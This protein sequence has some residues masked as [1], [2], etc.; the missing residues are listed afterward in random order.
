M[1]IWQKLHEHGGFL[2]RTLVHGRNKGV[3]LCYHR[4]LP[5]ALITEYGPNTGLIMPEAQFEQQMRHLASCCTPMPLDQLLDTPAHTGKRP[6]VVTFDDGTAD[7]LTY[8]LP[9]LE[10]YQIPATVY[11]TTGFVLQELR[12]WWQLLW[13]ALASTDRYTLACEQLHWATA[14]HASKIEC[15]KHIHTL[16]L[17][18]TGERYQR[19]NAELHRT[20]HPLAPQD[21]YLTPSEVGQLAQHPLITIGLH[22]HTHTPTRVLSGLEFEHEMTTSAAYLHAWTARPSHHFAYPY[23]TQAVICNRAGYQTST[24]T[25]RSACTTVLGFAK[26][27][28]RYALSRVSIPASMRMPHFKAVVG[29][30]L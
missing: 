6:V 25:L 9:I 13:A 14:S 28:D 4:V 29:C 24:H 7:N 5:Q 16:M 22:T 2:V 11:V 15:F 20:V 8:A 1:G 19:I 12:P 21:R 26:P 18:G 27:D 30:Y 10:K 17:S 23:G 3:I